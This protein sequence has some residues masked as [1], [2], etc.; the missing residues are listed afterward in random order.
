MAR[1]TMVDLILRVRKL[2]GDTGG[3]PVFVDDDVQEALDKQRQVVRYGQ[4]DF[5][6]NQ[7]AVSGF[8]LDYFAGMG[9]W[10]QGAQLYALGA[11]LLTPATAD[12]L[13]GHWTFSTTTYPPV[14][15][16]GQTYDVYRAAADLLDEWAA[17]LKLEYSFS[18]DGQTFNR[19]DRLKRWTGWRQSIAARGDRSRCGWSVTT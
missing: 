6:S 18:A 3:S 9:D 19:G 2:I 10:E 1:S 5:D 17:R 14:Y 7:V 13:T 8:Y 15:V 11:V 16:V 4:L 12:L